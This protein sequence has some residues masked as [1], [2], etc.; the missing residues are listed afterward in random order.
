MLSKGYLP[1]MIY[2]S[3]SLLTNSLPLSR[4]TPINIKKVININ[5]LNINLMAVSRRPDK[6]NYFPNGHDLGC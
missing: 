1:L 4:V 6:L 2:Q 5:I 3:E